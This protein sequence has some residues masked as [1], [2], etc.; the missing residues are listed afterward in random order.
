MT[1]RVGQASKKSTEKRLQCTEV[2][3][4][5]TENER[6]AHTEKNASGGHTREKKKRAAKP[7]IIRRKDA[8]E[9][10]MRESGLKEDMLSRW[11]K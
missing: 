4:P 2:V 1:T 3:R 5:C 9:R 10:D 7:K 6:G 8:C 11:T